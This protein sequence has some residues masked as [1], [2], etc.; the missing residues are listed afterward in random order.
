MDRTKAAS[1]VTSSRWGARSMVSCACAVI[2]AALCGCG[3]TTGGTTTAQ[4]AASATVPEVAAARVA[5]HLN[6]GS[7]SLSAPS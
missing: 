5:L 7:Y 4:S 1:R 6:A 2:V 3:N